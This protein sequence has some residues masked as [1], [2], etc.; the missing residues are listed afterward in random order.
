MKMK[1]RLD[2]SSY[3]L[4]LAI[5]LVLSAIFNYVVRS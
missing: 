2:M 1:W 3:C 5:G 4:G